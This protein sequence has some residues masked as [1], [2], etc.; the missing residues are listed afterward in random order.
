MTSGGANAA[1]APP[2]PGPA[3]APLPGGRPLRRILLMQLKWMGDV[4][5]CT[6]AIRAARQA[7]PDAKI[8]FATGSEGAAV[9]EG[10]PHLDEVLLWHRGT[11]DLGMIWEIAR[12]R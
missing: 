5:M 9:L 2:L 3:L 1:A 4:L 12:R 7:F 8:D 6:P 10:N 11:A